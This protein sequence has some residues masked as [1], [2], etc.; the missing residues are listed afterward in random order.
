M[1]STVSASVV[2]RALTALA[3]AVAVTGAA[4][5]AAPGIA[6][7]APGHVTGVEP[8]GGQMELVYV[9]S[10]SMDRVIENVVLVPASGAPAPVYY[11]L[12]GVGGGV[13]HVTW[14][15]SSKYA[16][17]FADEHVLV[18][19]P[20]GGPGSNYTNW[21]YDDPVRGPASANQWETYLT[22]ELP[23]AID[24][25]FA[26]TGRNAI[27][28]LSMSAGPA[29]DLAIQAPHRYDAVA[30]YSGCG[31][32]SGPLGVGQGGAAVASKGGNPF[33]MCGPPGEPHWLAHDPLTRAGELRGEAIYLA[34]ASALADPRRP[35]AVA[36]GGATV[37]PVRE[38]RPASRSRRLTEGGV[39]ATS[40]E[41]GPGAHTR[42]P[43]ELDLRLSW[44]AVVGVALVAKCSGGPAA[45]A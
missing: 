2:R 30:S 27:G 25:H 42:G 8:V 3:A 31:I 6:Q 26:T 20:I 7:A 39:P 17:F 11:L 37:A 23:E 1:T 41:G 10:P 44:D 40:V 35:P 9:Y 4:L 21:R 14:R 29:L 18:V 13:D 43:F 5:T 12:H 34:P 45:T 28:G 32:N 33:N 15:H 19:S 22:E 38:A 16:E 24:A 36:V